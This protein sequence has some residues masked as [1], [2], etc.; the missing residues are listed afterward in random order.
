MASSVPLVMMKESSI[1]TCVSRS[2]ASSPS[3]DVS[4]TMYGML[5]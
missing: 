1:F 2:L 4:W 3:V 5:K